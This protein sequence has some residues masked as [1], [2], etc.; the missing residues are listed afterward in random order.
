MLD[1]SR[2][3]QA[4]EQV[5]VSPEGDGAKAAPKDKA[6]FPGA[7][8]LVAR[9]GEV[10]FHR[11]FG[12]RSLIPEKSPMLETTVF[13]VAS[14]TKAVVTTTLVMQ[15]VDKGQL[16]VDRRLTRIFQTFGTFGKEQMTVRHLLAHCSGYPATTP[17]YKELATADKGERLGIMC[18]RGAVDFVCTEIF[19]ARLENMPGRVCKYSDVG[20]ILLGI[21]VETLMGGKTLEKSAQAQIFQPLGM[22]DSG[23]IELAKIRRRGLEPVKDVI[24]PT[25]QCPWR[26]KLLWGEVHDDNAWAMGGVAGHAGLFS[27]AQDLH[28]FASEMIRCYHGRGTLVEKDTIRR[29][30]QLDGTVPASTWALGWDT[31]SKNASSSGRYLSTRSVGHLGYT[32]CSLWIDPERELELI[33]LTNRVHPSTE[34]NLIREFRPQIHDVVMETLGYG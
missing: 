22:L 13:D 4:M 11:A 21:A 12:A 17:F 25:A 16:E 33:L 19:R 9:S 30:W 20:F 18:S 26:G 28:L 8:L 15:L 5:S 10:V 3:F 34:N 32:G 27:T 24:A 31:P 1:W 23:F 2:V 7:V 14:L 29:F 6:V